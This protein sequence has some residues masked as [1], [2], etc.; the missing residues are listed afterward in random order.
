VA[1]KRQTLSDPSEKL[2]N[3][4]GYN[5]SFRNTQHEKKRKLSEIQPILLGSLLRLLSLNRRRCLLLSLLGLLCRWGNLS[6][7]SLSDRLC[8]GDLD[9]LN[10]NLL[11]SIVRG[12]RSSLPLLLS[13]A[14]ALPR[15]APLLPPLFTLLL[16]TLLFSLG[17]LLLSGTL[18]NSLG[19]LPA[20]SGEPSLAVE[21]GV[22]D[23]KGNGGGGLDVERL[24]VGEGG[25][26]D[27]N[28]ELG[29]EGEEV[30]RKLGGGV[31]RGGADLDGTGEGEEVRWE[32]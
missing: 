28:G 5:L 22:V 17:G 6:S 1:C 31:D 23:G 32:L 27:A 16:L 10:N 29:D 3:A 21:S 13:S 26:G 30:G 9:L 4:V 15:R 2:D 12:S 8:H 18:G 14:L 7:L 11:L 25:V 20:G 19:L 24:D